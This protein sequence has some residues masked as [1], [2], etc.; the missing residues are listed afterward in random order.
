M[1]IS[2]LSPQHDIN[3]PESLDDELEIDLDKDELSED[4]K[5]NEKKK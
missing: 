2:K 3:A 4:L 5:S 1:D